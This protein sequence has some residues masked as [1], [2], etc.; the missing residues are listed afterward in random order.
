VES[1]FPEYIY[2]FLSG[3]A[4]FILVLRIL[5]SRYTG[6]QLKVVGEELSKL[7]TATDIKATFNNPLE[8][9]FLN[10]LSRDLRKSYSV[11]ITTIGHNSLAEGSI[12]SNVL[13]DFVK[14]GGRVNVVSDS[15][16]HNSINIDSYRR[17]PE[18][19][20]SLMQGMF[21]I[22][23]VGPIYFGIGSDFDNL[24]IARF[25]GRGS[26]KQS[27]ALGIHHLT[28]QLSHLLG[29]DHCVTIRATKSPVEYKKLILPLEN[30]AKTIDR[31][32]KRLFVVFKSRSV[33]Q[34][35]AEQRY[36][37]GSSYVNH[38]IEEHNERAEKFYAALGRGMICRE[39]YNKSEIISYVKNRKHGSNVT[40]TPA[41]IKE[42]VILWR[43]AIR[44][45]SN[46]F[47]GLTET[48]LPFKYEI[49]NGTHFIMHEAIGQNDEGRMNAFCVT[50]RDFC[51][52]PMTDFE[53]IW[54]N[55]L[56]LE[57]DKKNIVKWIEKE[58]LPACKL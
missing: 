17:V 32:P 15:A 36:G 8:S 13:S 24:A 4:G 38:Y 51:E 33:I 34:A 30:E 47:V 25:D 19:M 53:I 26:G 54:N 43:D 21:V 42:T 29:A 10:S 55:I 28:N 20:S 31:L 45:Q 3:I 12:L 2:F 22:D 57:R 40:L 52:K 49:I 41:Q 7:Q 39:I 9:S 5:E 14:D 27:L 58:V 46:Y 23:C 16:Q 44:Y 50:G 56:P 48:R 11:N 18:I 35:I 1:P 37:P 6:F